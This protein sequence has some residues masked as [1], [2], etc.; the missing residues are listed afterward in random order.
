MF[1]GALDR[2]DH[3]AA[4]TWLVRAHAGDVLSLCRAIVRDR[5]T[6]EDLAQDTFASAF[7]S[8]VVL[9]GESSPRS[10]LL[11]IARNRCI[12]HLRRDRR[13]PY[14]LSHE[15][16]V[17]ED[18]PDDGAAPG[19]ELLQRRDEVLRALASLDE[20]TRALVVLRFRHGLEYAELAEVFG[21]KEG[22]IRMRLSRALARMRD[23]LGGARAKSALA[24]A[25]REVEVSRP[26]MP[27]AP[28]AEAPPVPAAALPAARLPAA[29][30][31]APL[32]TA[33]LPPPAAPAVPP[34]RA[35][36][37]QRPA[38]PAAPLPA[39]AFAEPDTLPPPASA[40]L[41]SPAGATSDTSRAPDGAPPE[42]AAHQPATGAPPPGRLL[43]RRVT[44]SS[45]GLSGRSAVDVDADFAA[46]L[47]SLD[48]TPAPLLARLEALALA[49]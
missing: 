24:P 10:W 5:T 47:A 48:E 28:R 38:G 1:F 39:A 23:E 31:A 34:A 33:P 26:P 20:A 40:P 21:Q 15:P 2:G 6:A 13:A 27:S 43:R 14:G 17:I 7:R 8:L 45:F 42:T 9:R 35:P 29:P 3:R 41:A 32:P 30:R 37:V 4:A 12:D 25:R 46:L 16:E 44:A 11:S 22:T 18:A 19:P 36:A 49:V